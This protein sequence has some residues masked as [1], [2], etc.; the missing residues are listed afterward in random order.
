MNEKSSIIFRSSISLL[1]TPDSCVINSKSERAVY[2]SLLH[3]AMNNLACPHCPH[4]PANLFS[5]V[6]STML[7]YLL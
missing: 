4:L 6:C 1:A 2:P 5:L 3:S 7:R